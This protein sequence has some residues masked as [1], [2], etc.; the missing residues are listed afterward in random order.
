MGKV[1][2]TLGS[3]SKWNTIVNNYNKPH[4]W[5][6][7]WQIINSVGVYIAIWF[8]MYLSI[9]VSPWLIAFFVILAAGLLVRIFIIFHDCT[10]GSFFES[11]RANAFWGMITGILT[12]TPYSQWRHLHLSHHWSKG[13]A[14]RCSQ[15]FLGKIHNFMWN[16]LTK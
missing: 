8:L 10:H 6:A 11:H 14:H 2:R 13:S 3:I 5:L 7:S 15:K 1:N 4:F 16:S 9:S 12:F